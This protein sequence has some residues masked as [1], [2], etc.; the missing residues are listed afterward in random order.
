M[1]GVRC[2]YRDR[3]IG[4]HNR[5]GICLV[6]RHFKWQHKD[7]VELLEAK[8]HRR[9]IANTFAEG[10]SQIILPGHEELAVFTLQSLDIAGGQN[11]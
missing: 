10:V 9:I 4:R 1:T 7:V 11:P 8:M 3:S 6:Q 2:R 5:A